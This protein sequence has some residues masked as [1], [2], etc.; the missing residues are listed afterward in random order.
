MRLR[1]NQGR[2]L[3][4]GAALA[5]VVLAAAGT[6]LGARQLATSEEPP[7]P[8]LTPAP[9][10]PGVLETPPPVMPDPNSVPPP[11]IIDGVSI[12]IPKGGHFTGPATGG[13]WGPEGPT[14]GIFS[15]ASFV[16]FN[17]TGAIQSNVSSADAPN[18]KPTLDAIS[19]LAT[20]ASQ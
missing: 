5:L 20:K 19:R 17:R 7:P 9:P 18:L 4:Y 13:G 6:T 15:G 11:L 16:L 12:P 3:R 2:F 1:G 8:N 14:Y 10:S